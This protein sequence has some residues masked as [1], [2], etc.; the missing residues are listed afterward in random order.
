VLDIQNPQNGGTVTDAVLPVSGVI[1]TKNGGFTSWRLEYGSGDDP[2]DWTVIAEG[3][4][5]VP[6]PG[7]PIY[8]W[9]LSTVTANPIT[10]R[11][12]LMN[13]EDY[14][15]EKRVTFNINLPTPTPTAT[16]PATEVPPTAIPTDTSVPAVVTPS[17]T[18]TT[19]PVP[20]DTPTT[21]AP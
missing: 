1:D 21:P 8:T 18:P 15:A 2:S 17:E 19:A 4:N 10:L 16:P 3:N 11:L 7:G 9:D 13:G 20:T 14:H 12:Y 6:Q 5:P